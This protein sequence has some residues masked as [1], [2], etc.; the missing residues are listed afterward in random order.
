VLV[1]VHVIKV[2]FVFLSWKNIDPPEFKEF[3]LV[4]VHVIKFKFVFK[5]LKNIDPPDN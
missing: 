1:K 4:K 3:V 5:S 2:K